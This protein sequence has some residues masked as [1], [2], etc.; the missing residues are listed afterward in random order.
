MKIH[1]KFFG[2]AQYSYSTIVRQIYRIFLTVGWCFIWNYV[3]YFTLTAQNLLVNN[4]WQFLLFN[5]ST[6]FLYWIAY[7]KLSCSTHF[8]LLQI[9]AIHLLFC[10]IFFYFFLNMKA[11]CINSMKRIKYKSIDPQRVIKPN[12]WLHTGPPKNQAVYLRALSKG[13]SDRLGAV[14]TFQGACSG[15]WSLIP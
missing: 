9:Y 3:F 2:A 13:F 8:F 6:I 15:A 5:F 11:H 1:V 12:S 7:K 10:C 4:F 14:T